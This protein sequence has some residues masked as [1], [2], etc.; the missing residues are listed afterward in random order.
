MFI[1]EGII[2]HLVFLFVA[3]IQKLF[4]Q[5]GFHMKLFGLPVMKVDN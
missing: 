2:F 4:S 5:P 1:N 3:G